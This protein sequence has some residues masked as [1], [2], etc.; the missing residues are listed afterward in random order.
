MKKLFTLI[1]FLT[2][3]L[4][5]K[6]GEVIVDKTVDYSTY[7]G[8][9]FYVMGYVPE[10]IDGVMTD[11]GANYRYATQADLD[12]DGDAKWKDGESS[13]ATVKTN[14]GTEYQ[15]V[16][17]AGPYWHQYF[18]AT[19]IPTEIGGSYTVKALVKASEACTI[20][21]PMQWNWSGG[22]VAATVDIPASEDFVEVT[23]PFLTS[24]RKVLYRLGSR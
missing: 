7:N 14:D 1:A 3:F 13:E 4:G 9:P 24:R 20:N 12:G 10:W 2:C 19:G 16:T 15:K 18:I 8:F 23:L 21:V 17:G 5:A 22:N 6:A 11:F